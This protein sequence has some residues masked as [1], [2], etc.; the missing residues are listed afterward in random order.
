MS[1]NIKKII[2][3]SF[4]N[5]ILN[6][7]FLATINK[8]DM[9]QLCRDYVILGNDLLKN[10]EIISN[11]NITDYINS[12]ERI[13]IHGNKIKYKNMLINFNISK[14]SEKTQIEFES[15]LKLNRIF[16]KKYF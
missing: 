15:Y 16:G 12:N 6:A 5:Q 14:L 10:P 9:P 2:V 11:K 7:N 1:R 4:R 8:K 13:S 3:S